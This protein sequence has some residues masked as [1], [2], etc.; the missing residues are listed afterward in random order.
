WSSLK[1][2]GVLRRFGGAEDVEAVTVRGLGRFRNSSDEP[3]HDGWGITF[4]GGSGELLAIGQS[5]WLIA[6]V[7]LALALRGRWRVASVAVLAS[8]YALWGGNGVY[9]SAVRLM[10]PVFVLPEVVG[11]ASSAALLVLMVLRLRSR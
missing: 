9:L 1:M 6:G 5:L 11:L 4:A 2:Y 10:D 7:G 8:W 3:W